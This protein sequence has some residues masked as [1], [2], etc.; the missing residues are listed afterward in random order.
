MPY[1]LAD[2]IERNKLNKQTFEIPDTEDI[3]KLK[4][5]DHVKLIFE[6]T[7]KMTNFRQVLNVCGF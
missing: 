6:N 2:C 3:S 5:G 4:V 7:E 1:I